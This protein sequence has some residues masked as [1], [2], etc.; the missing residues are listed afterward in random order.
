MVPYAYQPQFSIKEVVVHEVDVG[1][2]DMSLFSL[3][4]FF[5]PAGM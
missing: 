4:G 1:N 2:H 5:F 3:D